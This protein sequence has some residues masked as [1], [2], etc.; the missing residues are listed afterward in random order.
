L[1]IAEMYGWGEANGEIDKVRISR[2]ERSANWLATTYETQS[3]PS[4]FMSFGS[5]EVGAL[6]HTPSDSVNVADSVVFKHEIPIADDVAIADAIVYE[7]RISLADDV[8]VTDAVAFKRL[9]AL[10]DSISVTDAVAFKRLLSLADSVSVS[11]SIAYK[12]MLYLAESIGITDS[13]NFKYFLYLLESVNISDSI[14]FKHL[15]SLSDS[16]NVTDSFAA[17]H[18]IFILDNISILDDME[19]DF[20]DTCGNVFQLHTDTYRVFLPVPEY[21]GESG[22]INNEIMLFDFW[23]NERDT[24]TIGINSEPIVLGGTIFACGDNKETE[25]VGIGTKFLNIHSMMDAHEKVRITGLNDCFDAYYI[26]KN[27]RHA[28]IRGSPYAYAWQLTLEYVEAA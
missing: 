6:L 7:H 26:I 3:E 12:H 14:F 10:A 22:S 21:G 28:T 25:M 2:Y 11:D 15:I 16:V 24:D 8:T 27:F 19:A 1:R 5:E 9:L 17:K 4:N 13:I 18:S 20:A 23:I